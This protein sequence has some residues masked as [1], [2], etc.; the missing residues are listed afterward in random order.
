MEATRSKKRVIRDE[1][2]TIKLRAK[3]C[4]E[5]RRHVNELLDIEKCLE[6]EDEQVVIAAVKALHKIFSRFLLAGEMYLEQ[7]VTEDMKLTKEEEY[8]HW[9]QQQYT[10]VIGKFLELLESNNTQLREIVLSVL[11]KFVAK[12]GNHPITKA[13]AKQMC[14]P[15]KL[16]QKILLS[17]LSPNTNFQNVLAKFE[18]F[19]TYDDARYFIFRFLLSDMRQKSKT[20]TGECYLS[21]V[22]SLLEHA[23]FPVTN[24]EVLTNFLTRPPEEGISIK[25]N[26]LKEQKKLFTTVWL[27][28]LRFKLSPSLYKRVLVILHD[29]VMPY[30]T[31][32]L[33]L[34]DFL[35]DSFNVGGAISLLALNGLFVLVHKYNLEYPDFFKKLYSLLEPSIFHVKYRARFFFLTDLFLTS[36]HLP[37]YLVA[38]F[39]KKIARI[40]LAAPPSG[41]LVALPLVYNLIN[42]HPNCKN[43]LHRTDGCTDGDE[44]PYDPTEPDPAKCR[45]LDSSL[46]EIKTLQSHYYHEVKKVAHKIDNPLHAEE[47]DLSKKLDTT[48][49]D[50]FEEEVR[51]KLKTAHLTFEPP[52]GLLGTKDDKLKLCWTLE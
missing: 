40:A 50:L 24:T 17:L 39:A 30:M 14:F 43:L 2:C 42:R 11:M 45:A 25:V 28:F 27:E 46:W 16:F 1:I 23:T 31:N 7:K 21:N 3:R 33:L 12:E 47:I 48:V 8:R 26:T 37:A 41:V 38:A 52:K 20:E 51:K 18:E 6:G 4:I 19:F 36:T 34:S 22:L 44:D 49:D 15:T 13:P 35:T 5:N 29:K 10:S 9:L 32:P